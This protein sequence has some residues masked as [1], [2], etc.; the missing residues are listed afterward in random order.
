MDTVSV[1]IPTWN[2]AGTLAAAIQST[3]DQTHPVLE[4]LVCDDGST[5]H[6]QQIVEDFSDARV[7]WVPGEPSGGPATP[8]N[9]GIALSRGT[10]LAFLDSDDRWYPEKLARQ[11][12]FAKQEKLS[13]VCTNADRH[14]PGA[15]T[16]TFHTPERIA[17]AGISDRLPFET[18]VQVNY[19]ICSTALV[20]RELLA[21]AGS[22]P[23]SADL[24]SVED[25]ALW[26]RV[27]AHAPFGYLDTALAIYADAPAQSIRR[28][29]NTEQLQQQKIR[30]ALSDLLE[31]NERTQALSA[32]RVDLIRARLLATKVASSLGWYARVRHKSKMLWYHFA[33]LPRWFSTYVALGK[34][35][36]HTRLFCF[37]PF[38]QTGGSERVHADILESVGY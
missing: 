37:F 2:R 19:V 31:W 12:A 16:S 23:E 13:A 7:K 29:V 6:S 22:F 27:A 10:W 3:L 32:E 8:R 33:L 21:R 25:Y 11:L 20:H 26:L 36:P 28:D 4:V 18:L 17:K 34:M 30:A 9:R 35:A 14:V 1:I 24:R 38:Y 5:D 15:S